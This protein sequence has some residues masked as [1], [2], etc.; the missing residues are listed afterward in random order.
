MSGLYGINEAENEEAYDGEFDG[1]YDGEYEEARRPRKP[2]RPVST[3]PRGS[4]YQP[5]PSVSTV[6]QAQ[7]QAALARVSQQINVNSNAIKTV[8]AR[9]RSVA[10]D[11]ARLSTQMKKGTGDRHKDILAVRKDLQMTR[12]VSALLPLLG[13]LGGDSNIAAFAPL[14]LL[15]NDVSADPA[16]GGTA[17][18]SGGLFGIGGG[19]STT[20]IIA[21][22]ALSGALGGSAAK[23]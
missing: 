14:L 8:D 21:L 4:A 23:A 1:E 9:V 5:R 15:S 7:L 11:T 2:A 13:L 10:S 17:Q 19:N 12:E 18:S 6:T 22:L 20:G 3:A 16:A